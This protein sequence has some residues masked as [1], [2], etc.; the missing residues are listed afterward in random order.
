MP[1]PCLR[2]RRGQRAAAATAHRAETRRPPKARPRFRAGRPDCEDREEDRGKR[3]PPHCAPGISKDAAASL[4][5]R[6]VTAATC[7]ARGAGSAFK[8]LARIGPAISDRR[9][10]Q[11]KRA[12]SGRVA[13][14]VDGSVRSKLAE[15]LAQVCG[16]RLVHAVCDPGDAHSPALLAEFFRDLLRDRGAIP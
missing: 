13:V 5:P 7:P 12:R 1:R 16:G 2:S 10:R 6:A 15:R 8:T 14:N 11:G 9:L 4:S 3:P